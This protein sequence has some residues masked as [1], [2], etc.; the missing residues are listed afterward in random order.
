MWSEGDLPSQSLSAGG[1]LSKL[2]FFFFFFKLLVESGRRVFEL[3]YSALGYWFS[4]SILRGGEREA[5]LDH[6]FSPPTY[7]CR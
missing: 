5:G 4:I 7:A 2:P 1:T 6:L 3:S